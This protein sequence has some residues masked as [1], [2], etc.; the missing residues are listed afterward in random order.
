MIYKLLIKLFLITPIIVGAEATMAWGSTG[1]RT[2]AYIAQDMLSAQAKKQVNE[3][4]VLEGAESLADIS[5]WADKIRKERRDLPSHTVQIPLNEKDYDSQRDCEKR[6][7]TC[8]VKGIEE[9][10]DLLSERELAPEKRLEALKLVVHLIGD[11]HQPLHASSQTMI[12]AIYKGK[13]YK[14][15]GMHGIWDTESVMQ[16]N[17][18]PRQLATALEKEIPEIEQGTPEQWAN[19]SHALAIQY[20]KPLVDKNTRGQPIVVSDEYLR[21]IGP[22]V[23]LRLQQSGVRLGRLLNSIFSN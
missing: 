10:I 15:H 1:H 19:E 8:V 13:P 6:K 23:R 21:S 16:F 20:Y 5:V 17:M 14:I 12:P 3:L 9:Q 4:L 11:I 22:V 2:I 7:K 18:K